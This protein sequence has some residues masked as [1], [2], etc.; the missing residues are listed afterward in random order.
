MAENPAL[1]LTN[2]TNPAADFQT[3]LPSAGTEDA[4]RWVRFKIEPADM[5]KD[6]SNY[7][8]KMVSQPAP[9]NRNLFNEFLSSKGSTGDSELTK[10]R[11]ISF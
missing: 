4:F 9:S 7:R 6:K 5:L 11:S 3:P 10:N 1:A 2:L 8:Q